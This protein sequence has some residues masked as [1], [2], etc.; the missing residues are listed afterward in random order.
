VLIALTIAEYGDWTAWG[1]ILGFALGVLFLIA[2]VI[3]ESRAEDPIIPLELFRIRTFTVSMIATFFATFGFATAIIFLPLWFQVVQNASTT[4]SGY[5]LMPF[6]IGLIASSIAAGQIVSRTG[7]YKWIL[8]AGMA[9]ITAG[10]LL[11]TNL[12]ADTPT[13]ILWLWMVIAGLG[14]GPTFA[15]FTLI[16]QNAVPY[17]RLGTATSDLTLVRQIGTSVGL[18][19]AFTLFVN[20]LTWNLLR[21]SIIAAGAPAAAVPPTAPAGFNLSQQLTDVGTGT[22]SGLG[23]LFAQIPTQLQPAFIAGFNQAFSIA[24]SDAMWIG[25]GAGLIALI[26]AFFLRELPLR[27][28]HVASALS[29]AA[30]R[31]ASAVD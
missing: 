10:L 30:A 5:D 20:N 31:R 28:T 14:V 6:L 1:V 8:V 19:I 22:S 11:F 25:V 7:H 16:V 12:R 24:L 26:S 17:G 27:S 9:A 2:F 18:T 23:S 4:A 15:V 3:I 29:A 13:P 21:T